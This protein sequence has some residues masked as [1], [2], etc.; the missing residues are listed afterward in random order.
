MI[1]FQMFSK[2]VVLQNIL[3][4]FPVSIFICNGTSLHDL[5]FFFIAVI[6]FSAISSLSVLPGFNSATIFVFVVLLILFVS[7]KFCLM[8]FYLTLS[9]SVYFLLL[10]SDFF[11][12]M[13]SAIL[14]CSMLPLSLFLMLSSAFCAAVPTWY[15]YFLLLCFYS[16][17]AA[18]AVCFL[19][20]FFFNLLYFSWF[21]LLQSAS[22][23]LSDSILFP[24][25]AA[26][27]VS[28]ASVNS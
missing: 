10:I 9:S 24:P 11:S 3:R 25:L 5:I 8:Q 16:F 21:V 22:L 20:A 4:L 18:F 26:L 1:I 6:P 23:H 19:F 28:F 14:S 2:A 7:V 15:Y 17:Y 12:S 13:L 27:L